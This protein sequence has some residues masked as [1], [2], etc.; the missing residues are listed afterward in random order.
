MRKSVKCGSITIGGGAP[1]SIQ[2]MTNV[3]SHDEEALVK[4][5]GEL[6]AAGILTLIRNILII[7]RW[8][9]IYFKK[10]SMGNSPIL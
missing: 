8:L 5:I 6:T 10:N 9:L 7:T 1:V 3:D 4:Q 2:S